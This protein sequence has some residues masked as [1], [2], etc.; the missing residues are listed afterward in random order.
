MRSNDIRLD[1]ISIHSTRSA[2]KIGR[3]LITTNGYMMDTSPSPFM[4]DVIQNV[5]DH[6]RDKIRTARQREEF[7]QLVNK[8][9]AGESLGPTR[10]KDLNEDGFTLTDTNALKS[11][12][13]ERFPPPPPKPRPMLINFAIEWFFQ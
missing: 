1:P 6:L 8:A 11:Y 13:V 4:K 7:E 5:P 10:E 3:N 12:L 2:D 9:R